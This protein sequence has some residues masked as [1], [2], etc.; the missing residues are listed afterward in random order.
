MVY[1]RPNCFNSMK[2]LYDK[3]QK[4]DYEYDKEAYEKPVKE[5]MEKTEQEE[6]KKENGS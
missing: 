6:K 4:I 5:H 3:L 2:Y 1:R